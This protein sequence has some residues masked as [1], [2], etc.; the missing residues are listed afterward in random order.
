MWHPLV[1]ALIEDLHLEAGMADDAG[2]QERKG[3]LRG[4]FRHNGRQVQGWRRS[5]VIEAW[6]ELMLSAVRN[7]Q[8][9]AI[10]S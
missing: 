7:G 4:E 10:S 2:T 6:G 3:F 5:C 9:S 1:R 8:T